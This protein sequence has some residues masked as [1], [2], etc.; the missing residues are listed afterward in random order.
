LKF[1][2]DKCTKCGAC[3]RVCPVEIRV[4][5]APNSHACVR[6]LRCLHECRYGALGL[7]IAGYP[8]HVGAPT[9]SAEELHNHGTDP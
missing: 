9:F 4:D 7:D 6:C 8:V 2:A 5:E 3:H 1:A